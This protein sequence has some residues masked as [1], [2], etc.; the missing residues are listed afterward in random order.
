MQ[1]KY[2][3]RLSNAERQECTEVI[4]K[5]NGSSQKVR[6]AQMLLKADVTG[7]AWT[8]AKIADAFGCRMRTVEKLRQRLVDEGFELA[9]NGKQRASPPVPPKLDGA[10]EAQLIALRL[11]QPPAGYSHWTMH[12]LADRLVTLEIV[13]NISAETVRETLKKGIS[14]RMNAY[15]AIPPQQDAEFVAAMEEVLE[16]YAKPYHPQQS[17]VCMDEQPIQLV[18]ESKRSLPA[19]AAHPPRVDYEYERN[20]TASIF[21]FCEPLA[22]FRQATAREH[23]TKQD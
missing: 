17:V 18:R 21:M 23:R 11:G 5:L 10:G 2:L 6:R 1:K 22:G 20:G 7:S 12:L 4:R 9:L 15:W 16:V 19:T 3:V 13:E 14:R 8:D